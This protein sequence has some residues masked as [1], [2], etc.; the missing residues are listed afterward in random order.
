MT[1]DS[2]KDF[3]NSVCAGSF[4]NKDGTMS[5]KHDSKGDS[6]CQFEGEGRFFISFYYG[7]GWGKEFYA[8]C[9]QCLGIFIEGLDRFMIKGG[10]YIDPTITFNEFL[11]SSSD[12][13][14]DSES[15]SVSSSELEV[16]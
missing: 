3:S 4:F 10:E 16:A 9:L 11:P 2:D 8:S 14:S 13:N 15:L 7:G 5:E 6:I 1:T 12:S